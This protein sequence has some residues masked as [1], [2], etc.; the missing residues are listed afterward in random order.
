MTVSCMCRWEF[1]HPRN[2]PLV[3]KLHV[4]NKLYPRT[5]HFFSSSKLRQAFSFQT[6]VRTINIRSE[7]PVHDM[8]LS[9]SPVHGHLPV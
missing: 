6:M 5:A 4:F 2:L 9:R 3:W 1:F 7:G 8:T